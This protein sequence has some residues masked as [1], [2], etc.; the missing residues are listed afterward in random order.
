MKRIV[1]KGGHVVDP[2]EKINRV[3][4]LF[5]KNGKIEK[6]GKF[7]TRGYKEIDVSGLVVV[8]G[9]VDIHTHLREP[10]REDSET[11]LSGTTAAA[12]GGFTSIACMPNTDP[13]IDS[14]DAV[15][16]IYDRAKNAPI[17]VYPI[18]SITKGQKGEELTD[19]IDCVRAGAVAFSEDGKSVANTDLML[20]A[21]E[22]SKMLG[23]PIISHCEEPSLSRN[24][25]MNE[26]E[27]SDL[28]GL[29]G[30]PK[31]AEEVMVYRDIILSEYVGAR[32]HIAHI[33]THRSVIA[34]IE[35][36]KRGA[37]I[38]SE[39]T[40]HH[41]ALSDTEVKKFDPNFKVNP[42]LRDD[43]E[44]ALLRDDLVK[45]RIDCIATDHAPHAE[46]DKAVEFPLAPFGVIGL[47]TAVGVI[48]TEFYHTKRLSL[49]QIVSLMSTTPASILNLPA[50]TLKRGV[51]ADI[52]VLDTQKEWIVEGFRSKSKNSPF[53][54]RMLIGK[55]VMTISDG[56][57]VYSDGV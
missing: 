15:R 11:I 25:V 54:G 12:A 19:M 8:P 37:H 50:G 38:T 18:A 3:T 7:S 36:K 55:A 23:V 44:L 14:I 5:I 47:E 39:I 52:T 30:I 45:G 41:L 43:R 49:T 33:S 21:L 20:N 6:I 35:A 17:K 10:G 32:L 57:I 9:F 1:L 51:A 26:G 46:Q 40:P 56:E 13:P 48:L 29:K 31:A 42:P 16:F 28:L 24:G 4:D 22:Y 53:I 27:V 2:S 34:V